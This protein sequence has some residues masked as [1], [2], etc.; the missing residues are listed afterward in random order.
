[1]PPAGPPTLY[2]IRCRV[3]LLS[4][5]YEEHVYIKGKPCYEDLMTHMGFEPV[6][7][8]LCEWCVTPDTG[9]G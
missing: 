9:Y 1:M 4:K 3:R 5:Y 6:T 8:A 2:S 7:D